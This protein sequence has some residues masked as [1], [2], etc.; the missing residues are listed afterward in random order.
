MVYSVRVWDIVYF[1]CS[2]LTMATA[3]AA[4]K[5]QAETGVAMVTEDARAVSSI[6]GATLEKA[7]RVR[8]RAGR[9]RAGRGT[10]EH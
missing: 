8:V 9:V 4:A 10:C 1:E 5:M 2:P 3:E 7:K 6:S